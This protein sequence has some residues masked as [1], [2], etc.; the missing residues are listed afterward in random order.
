[1]FDPGGNLDL[2]T[3]EDGY[4]WRINHF[5]EKGNYENPSMT[6]NLNPIRIQD[7]NESPSTIRNPSLTMIQDVTRNPSPIRIQ[8]VAKNLSLP[9]IED[10]LT[11][12]GSPI[13]WA[14]SKKMK[15]ALH[16]LIQ[17]K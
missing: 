1:M 12:D 4:D 3:F 13:T 11:Y 15:E 9:R 7:N 10:P 2:S 17:A 16:V 8:N 5:E 14:C 6:R